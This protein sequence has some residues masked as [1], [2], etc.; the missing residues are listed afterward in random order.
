V[1]TTGWVR[2][3]ELLGTEHWHERVEDDELTRSEGTNHDTTRNETDGSEADETNLTRKAAET[4]EH[5]ALTTSTGLVDLG[6]EGISWVRN[7]GGGNTGN[8][9]GG[10]GDSHLGTTTEVLP[11]WEGS[12]DGLSGST[13]D[14]ELGH[15]VWDLLEEDWDKS[16]VEAT[17]ETV[18]G[19][20]RSEGTWHGQLGESLVRDLT[21][22]GSLERAEEDIS[23]ELSTG[24]STEVDVVAVIPARLVAE[25]LGKGDLEVLKA[26]ELEPT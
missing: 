23:D 19:G 5:G 20:D 4:D 26:S 3:V 12:V 7:D 24:G 10:D 16:R 11:W 17:D 21:D 9:T 25:G 6:E 14:G 1:S 15:G 2:E 8:D 22:A 18:L 13:L